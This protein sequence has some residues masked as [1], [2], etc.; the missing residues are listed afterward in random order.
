[1]FEGAPAVWTPLFSDTPAV[2][3]APAILL[4]FAAGLAALWPLDRRRGELLTAALAAVLFAA[5]VAVQAFD[6]L[7]G[8]P[9]AIAASAFYTG[10]VLAVGK[11]L[12]MRA[13]RPLG[14][15]LIAGSLFT[16]P[17]LTVLFAY[18]SDS[19]AARMLIQN[20]GFGALFAVVLWRVRA[21]AT[22]PG[23]DR[24]LF[25]LF[26]VMTAHFIPRVAL[27]LEYGFD[28]RAADIA[29]SGVWVWMQLPAAALGIAMMLALL[30]ATVRDLV[31]ELRRERDLDPLTGLLNRRG[32]ETA[33]ALAMNGAAPAGAI[34]ADIDHFKRINDDH[35]HAAGDAALTAFAAL[36]RREAGPD[37]LTARLG[38]EEFAVL[39]PGGDIAA[40]GRAAEAVR[41]GAGSLVLA[42]GPSLLTASFG[43]SERRGEED[44]WRLL[45]RA[46]QAL[47]AAKRSGRN[48]VLPRPA[49]A[50][51]Q[52]SAR[53]PQGAGKTRAVQ[54]A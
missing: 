51:A 14:R 53:T 23:P 41:A 2:L 11:A 54:P 31:E 6:P 8:A 39:L 12:C 19:I 15:P 20:V 33:A 13:S 37:A 43:L 24:I 46:D 38:G 52:R 29:A 25:A 44:V 1:M 22:R 3:I 45:D 40:A 5:A 48:K 17:A 7:A 21:M 18:G 28:Q 49:E 50:S 42:E 27:T 26:V 30:T 47:Y 16:I 32:F 9:S 10:C 34:V 35:G 4:I 36:L